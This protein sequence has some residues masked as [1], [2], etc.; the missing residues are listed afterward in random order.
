M[1][2]RIINPEELGAP[3]GFSHGILAPAGRTLFVAGQIGDHADGSM[4]DGFVAQFEQALKNILAVVSAAGGDAESIGRM[5][6]YV[7]SR[8]DYLDNLEP[9]GRAYRSQMGRH[10]PAM[11]LVQVAGLVEDGALLE[12]E[13]T[14]VIAEGTEAG[15]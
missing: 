14:A 11:A 3:K 2:G 13:A 1:S 6:V 7:T 5:T 4:A 15:E 8:N 9:L 12:I 10:F